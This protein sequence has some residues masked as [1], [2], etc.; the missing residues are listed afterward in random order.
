MKRNQKVS[1]HEGDGSCC[2]DCF[3][4]ILLNLA[5]KEEKNLQNLLSF[6]SSFSFSFFL[7]M[8][9]ILMFM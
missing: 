6:V 7:I 4:L 8:I 5:H 2:C 3:S 1:S 9:S